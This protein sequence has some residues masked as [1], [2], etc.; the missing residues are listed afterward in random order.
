MS[1]E[2]KSKRVKRVRV[3]KFTLPDIEHFSVYIYLKKRTFARIYMCIYWL[4]FLYKNILKLP[5]PSPS[6]TPTLIPIQLPLIHEHLQRGACNVIIIT[7]IKTE[8][9]K[10]CLFLAS[11]SHNRFPYEWIE[12]GDRLG[13]SIKIF[14]WQCDFGELFLAV[15]ICGSHFTH[16][17]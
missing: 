13:I 11:P 8:C 16:S 1:K 5:T 10:M 15:L 3:R 6:R 17:M 12:C 7:T 14:H 4:I 2:R 9:W